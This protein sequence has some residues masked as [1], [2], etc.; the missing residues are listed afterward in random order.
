[1]KRRKKN[2]FIEALS[3]Q[4]RDL[5]GMRSMASRMMLSLKRQ[6]RYASGEEDLRACIE[7]MVKLSQMQLKIIPLEAELMQMMPQKQENNAPVTAEDEEIL[8]NAFKRWQERIKT[9]G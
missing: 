6:M 2:A 4:I 8:N 5:K 1:M 7:Q 9:D 3:S